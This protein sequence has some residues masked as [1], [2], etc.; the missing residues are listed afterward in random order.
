MIVIYCVG[1]SIR[2]AI[3][4][5][6]ARTGVTQPKTQSGPTLADFPPGITVVGRYDGA[7]GGKKYECVLNGKRFEATAYKSPTGGCILVVPSLVT[8]TQLASNPAGTR[9]SV[10]RE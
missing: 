7:K 6:A 5:E 3:K 2:D 8:A 1:S 4:E 9:P 10:E